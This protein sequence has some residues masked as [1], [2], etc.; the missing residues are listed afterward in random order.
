VLRTVQVVVPRFVGTSL[1]RH[2]KLAMLA[3]PEL[4]DTEEHPEECAVR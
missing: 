2:R 1:A 3:M 4:V